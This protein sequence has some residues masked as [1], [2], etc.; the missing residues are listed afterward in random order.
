MDVSCIDFLRD[1]HYIPYLTTPY[2]GAPRLSY[3]TLS[4]PSSSSEK[5]TLQICSTA[6]MDPLSGIVLAY[7]EAYRFLS[8]GGLEEEKY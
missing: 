3:Q 7:S 8:H 4:R 1:T 5:S 2:L 6:P